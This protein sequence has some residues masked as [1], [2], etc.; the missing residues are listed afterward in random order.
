MFGSKLSSYTSSRVISSDITY[1]KANNRDYYLAL[2]M[3]N[4]SR[5]IMGYNLSSSLISQGA[6]LAL[7]QALRG[8]K[9]DLHHSDGGCQYHS[10]GFVL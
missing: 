5:K 1:L 4:Q 6:I 10:H 2:T 3:D 9:Y 8:N 7:R